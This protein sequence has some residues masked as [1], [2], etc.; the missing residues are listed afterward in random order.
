MKQ[1]AIGSA[2]VGGKRP[3]LMAGPCVVEGRAMLEDCAGFLAEVA[4]EIGW[5]LVFKASYTKDNRLSDDSFSGIGR[6]K[7]LSLLSETAKAAG[8]PCITDIH[9]PEEAALAAEFVDCL[10]IPAFLC[11]QSSLLRAAGATGLPVNL[12]KGQFLAPEDLAF[13]AEKI[14]RAGSDK[15]ML[16]ERGSSLGYRDL[17]VDYRSFAVMARS[18]R[19][20]V[21]DL[22]HSQQQPGG[23]GGSSGGSREFMRPMARA[24]LALGIQGL[25]ME[26]HP[27]PE[28]AMSDAATQLPFPQAGE[29]LRDLADLYNA[30]EAGNAL[31]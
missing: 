4:K 8:L 26:V 9:Q 2:E 5:P 21:F 19:P 6:E 14:A 1:F 16:T 29:L 3:L 13:S 17:V 22:T 30:M 24:A 28:K 10:Q 25:F 23:S 12:K 20:V 18:G 27:E 15:V 31:P 11:R 7:A